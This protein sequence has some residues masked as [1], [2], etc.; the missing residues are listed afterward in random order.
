MIE[1]KGQDVIYVFKNHPGCVRITAQQCK[2]LEVV[3]VIQAGDDAACPRTVLVAWSSV[4]V[5]SVNSS[6]LCSF[7]ILTWGFPLRCSFLNSMSDREEEIT[8]G[9]NN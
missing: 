3:V 4:Q 1:E 9:G 5:I 8:W 6:W 2:S 7:G